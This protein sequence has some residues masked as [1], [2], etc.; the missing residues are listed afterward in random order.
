MPLEVL[1]YIAAIKL[2]ADA[3]SSVFG[4]IDKF[5]SLFSSRPPNHDIGALKSYLQNIDGKVNTL[6]V[7]N[8]AIMHKIDA[9]PVIVR[10]IVQEEVEFALVS[11]AYINLAS[12]KGTFFALKPGDTYDLTS[13]GWGETSKALHYLFEKDPRLSYT[14]ALIEACEFA[15]LA[16][17]NAACRI[18]NTLV[19]TRISQLRNAQDDLKHQL[20]TTLQTLHTVAVAPYVLSQ[21]IGAVTSAS[22]IAIQYAP[23]RTKTIQ[24]SK[25]VEYD[26]SEPV[27]C[28]PKKCKKVVVENHTVPDTAFSSAR[29]AAKAQ[30]VPPV[31][32]LAGVEGMLY[33][34]FH[35]EC[36]TLGAPV[37]S[38]SAGCRAR[39]ICRAA[40]GSGDGDA[41][42]QDR[43]SDRSPSAGSTADGRRRGN[44]RHRPAH[45]RASSDDRKVAGTLS[46]RRTGG[47]TGGRP[48]L[49]APARSLSE[50]ECAR[51]VAEACRPPQD[52]GVPVT[53]WSCSLLGTHVRSLGIDMSDSSVGRIL[54]AAPLQPH[55]QKMWLNSQDDEF[56]EKRDD[57]LRVYYEAPA[58]EH[59]ICL[60]EKT[61]IQA[62]ERRYPD[63]PMTPGTP[64]RREF[65]YIRHGTLALMGAFDVRRGKLFGFVSEDHTAMTFVD[66]LDAVDIC[67]PVGPGHLICDNLSAH[68]TDDVLDWLEAHPRWTRHFTPKHASWLNQIECMF[69][70]LDRRVLARGSFVSQDDLTQKLYAYMSWHNDTAQP[71]QWSYRP[72]SWGTSNPGS[73]SD[74]RN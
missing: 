43:G 42:G 69:G 3:T 40:R 55:R 13:Y 53:H 6:V 35:A 62:L 61:G 74:G 27:C 59:I 29:D 32:N 50:T 64:V 60:D 20:S 66:L 46:R 73:T 11:Q 49:G 16:T 9:M 19:Q 48:S 23:N 67:Y 4:A 52:V 37:A 21:N 54:R 14:P 57:V 38:R 71:F 30:L 7:Q 22:D 28:R 10:Q 17:K 33:R 18:I 63:L 26:C 36:E 47:Q 56:R 39:T 25:E 2:G 72:K 44:R 15:M 8:A 12:L 5:R 68:D 70:I 34:V 24:L 58:D 1:A 65:E 51:V 45:R 31:R 41:G